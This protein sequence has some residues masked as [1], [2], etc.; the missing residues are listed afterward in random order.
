MSEKRYE[1][2]WILL[3]GAFKMLKG[4]LLIAAGIGILKLV[5]KDIGD[6]AQHWI[7][8]L[9]VDPDNRYVHALLARTLS[10]DER[11]LKEIGVGTFFYA[12]LFLTEGTGLLLRKRWAVYFTI[13][14]T[15]SFIPLEVYEL[16]RHISIGKATLTIINVA[17]VIYLVLSLHRRSA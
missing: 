5:H 7:S 4:A 6:V 13:I 11:K 15:G 9:R 14:V 17:I 8:V 12:G 1:D 3:I 2:K 10:L 16:V